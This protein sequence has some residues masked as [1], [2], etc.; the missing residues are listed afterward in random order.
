MDAMGER[1]RVGGIEID[2]YILLILCINWL[3]NENIL[4]R[5]ENCT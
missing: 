4:Y 2:T 3:T 5:I 1:S